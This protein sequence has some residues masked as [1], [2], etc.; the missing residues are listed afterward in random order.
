MKKWSKW[1]GHKLNAFEK[2]SVR[3]LYAVASNINQT[4]LRL[5]AVILTRTQY[6]S[7]AVYCS[8]CFRSRIQETRTRRHRYITWRYI[9]AVTFY[10][11][12]YLRN[13]NSVNVLYLC[14]QVVTYLPEVRGYW[15]FASAGCPQPQTIFLSSSADYAH[16]QSVNA[17]RE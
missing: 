15:K 8:P 12:S 7:P 1:R 14:F 11:L 4:M 9:F 13:I 16:P 10:F 2:I 17:Y 3:F 6:L 5:V